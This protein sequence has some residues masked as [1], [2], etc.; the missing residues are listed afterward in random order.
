MANDRTRGV[1]PLPWA[2]VDIAGLVA[3]FGE[4]VTRPDGQVPLDEAALLVAARFR[5]GLDVSAELA[6]LDE[7]AAGCHAP[8]LD[9]LVAYL[10][11]D[12]GFAG[13]R[14][15]YYDPRNSFLDQVLA[16]RL[17]IP[18]SLAVLT[19]TVGRR[20]GVPLVGVGMPGHFLL[21]DQVDHDVFVDPFGGGRLLDARGCAAAF[22]AVHGAE[23]RFDPGYLTPVGTQLVVAR[24]LANLR[25]IY[26][27]RGDRASVVAVLELSNCLPTASGEDRGE[28]AAALA[29]TGRFAEAAGHYEQAAGQLGGSL[30]AEYRRNATR[31]RARL[32]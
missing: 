26:G 8:T 31:L 10:F 22:H 4:A 27:A 12:L 5:P 16:R 18:I 25:S 2:A 9:A 7:L 21:R 11:A 1:V 28:L 3:R 23:V 19:M 32:N 20:L 24:L 13:N 14:A 17:G 6:R 30:G 15:D 29:A